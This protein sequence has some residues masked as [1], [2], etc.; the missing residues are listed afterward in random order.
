MIGTFVVSCA[1]LLVIT[2]VLDR[3][4][5]LALGIA[6]LLLL[7][8]ITKLCGS[9]F[10][11]VVQ[12]SMVSSKSLDQIECGSG[13]PGSATKDEVNPAE[14]IMK[15]KVVQ[16]YFMMA[17]VVV[18]GIFLLVNWNAKLDYLKPRNPEV[19]ELNVLTFLMEMTSMWL[20]L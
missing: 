10:I 18:I 16:I 2:I 7:S 5:V 3:L 17:H 11:N 4:V 15:A 20:R 12:S 14:K 8:V 19:Y 1:V 6:S 13:S 9:R